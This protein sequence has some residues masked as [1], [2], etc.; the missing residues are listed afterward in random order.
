MAIEIE[1]TGLN[2]NGRAFHETGITS[3]IS[4]YGGV[5][6]LKSKLGPDQELTIRCVK[7]NTEAEMRVVGLIDV[8]GDKHSYGLALIDSAN[9]LW[10]IHFPVLDGQ[11]TPL[12]RLVLECARCHLLEVAHFN[13]IEMQIFDAN[14][15]VRRF[16]KACS[17]ATNWLQPQKDS[18]FEIIKQEFQLEETPLP[19]TA[20]QIKRKY[21][22]IATK[23]PACIRKPDGA[24]EI[25]KSEN[26][27]RGGLCFR[28]P[29]IYA[30]GTR[31]EV[32]VPYSPGTGNIFVPAEIVHCH[33]IGGG[34]RVGAVYLRPSDLVRSYKG[35]ST[36]VE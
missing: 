33:Q 8:I 27:S 13:E 25:V 11:E 36:I 18:S 9:D 35:T 1:A 15:H 24:E 26:I 14:H 6:I 4:R 16:C 30:A 20:A 22:R 17:A 29:R 31:I 34:F 28:S 7:T 5:V 21:E 12:T 32:S 3:S 10:G 23:A 2:V 19:P